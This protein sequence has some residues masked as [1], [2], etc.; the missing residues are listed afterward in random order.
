MKI[1]SALLITFL[2]FGC[3]TAGFNYKGVQVTVRQQS[4]VKA[5][6]G[7]VVTTG[8]DADSTEVPEHQQ[9]SDVAVPILKEIGK[10][11]KRKL[12]TF[13]NLAERCIKA[14][15]DAKCKS[16]EVPEL[17]ELPTEPG[18]PTDPTD[19]VEPPD[20][21]DPTIPEVNAEWGGG[22]LWKPVADSRGGVP[23]VLTA[24]QYSQGKVKLWGE[25]GEIPV[26]VEYRG[27]TNGDRETYFLTDKKAEDLPKNLRVQ[28]GS[29]VF[30]VPDPEI[31][32]E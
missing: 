10:A 12:E 8:Q 32:M 5:T 23:V 24:P 1:L 11:Y 7:S 29:L 21:T 18:E 15:L 19:P 25:L 17:P 2:L 9:G 28:V 27:R 16:L 13:E 22:S 26:T 30:L 31:R 3:T 6:E 20:P 4:D 14:G